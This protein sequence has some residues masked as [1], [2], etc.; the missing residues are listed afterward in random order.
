MTPDEGLRQRMD[1]LVRANA[2]RTA[3]R[4]L[5]VNMRSGE[6][7]L[8]DIIVSPPGCV[9]K[10]KV[11]EALPWAPG[12]GRAKATNIVRRACI[13]TSR[14]LGALTEMERTRLL[15]EV[16]AW[17]QTRDERREKTAARMEAVA[18]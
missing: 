7:K 1:A 14:T 8:S 10:S 2:V 11:H 16:R 13:G 4:D 17:E 15:R 12:I 18:A 3:K 5:K 6:I 9:R